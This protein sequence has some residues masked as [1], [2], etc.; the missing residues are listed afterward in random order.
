MDTVIETGQNFHFKNF[1][2][3]LRKKLNKKL[4]DNGEKEHKGHLQGHASR[5]REEGS[6]LQYIPVALYL[7]KSQNSYN[8]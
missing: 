8:F 2:P 1:P 7:I 5:K 4:P 6:E 3:P